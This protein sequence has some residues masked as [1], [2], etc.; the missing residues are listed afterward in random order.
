MCVCVFSEYWGS[1]DSLSLNI[2]E[3]AVSFFFSATDELEKLQYFED[4]VSR[5]KV[6]FEI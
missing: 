2:T 6:L 4:A 3:S 1:S 5:V